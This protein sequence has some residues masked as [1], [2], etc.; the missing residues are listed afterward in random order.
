MVVP[1]EI[2]NFDGVLNGFNSFMSVLFFILK[3]L[4]AVVLILLGTI[5]VL[6]SRGMRNPQ[7]KRSFFF[8]NSRFIVGMVY[9]ILGIGFIF[10]FMIYPLILLFRS[11]PDMLIIPLLRSLAFIP[12]D[13]I[14]VF[15]LNNNLETPLEIFVQYIMGIVSFLIFLSII[16]N[17]WFLNNNRDYNLSKQVFGLIIGFIAG[18]LFSFS[19]FLPLFLQF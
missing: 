4:F 3:Y 13:F 8:L 18:F 15:F 16:L 12:Q 2:F 11:I 7:M 10:D 17:I 14:N 5:S 1:L 6:R 19:R 9:F